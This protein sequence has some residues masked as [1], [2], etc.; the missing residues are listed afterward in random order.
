MPAPAVADEGSGDTST[1]AQP[2]ETTYGVAGS[3]GRFQVFAMV[4]STRGAHQRV[5]LKTDVDEHDPSAE[6]WVSVYPG[7]DWHE[8]ETWEMFGI[9]FDGHPALRHLYLPFEFE[10]HPLR[11]DYPLLAREV[12][13]WPGLV[14]VEPMPGEDGDDEERGRGGGVVTTGTE[15][16]PPNQLPEVHVDPQ[17]LRQLA[18]AQVN[19]ELDTGD[20][21]LNLG[22]QHPATHGTLRLVVRLD[23]ERVIAADPVI[24][25]MHR[26]YEKL[27]EFRTYPQITTLINRID[28]LSSFANE[29]PFIAGAEM[30]MGIEAPPRALYI[31][32]VLTEL[33]R[34]ATFLL[35]LGEMGLQVGAITPAFYGFRDRE[36]VLNLIEGVTGGRFHPNFNR[37]GGLKDDLPWGWVSECRSTMRKV[38]ESCDEFENLVVG[39]PIFEQRTRS[40][41]IIPAELGAAYGVS[42]SNLRAS[43]VDWDLRR[44]GNP[45]LPYD[46]L[47]W[48][49]WTHPDGDS[50][51][52]YWV[53]LQETRESAR[54][55]LQLVEQMPS[56]PI[57]AKVPRIIKVPRARS[58]STPRTRSARWA[59]TSS[60]R[61]RPGRSA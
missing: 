23:G 28:W 18:E 27:T 4:A 22:P 31:R 17:M 37:I 46:E 19:V 45:H 33:S 29:V 25:Y 52:R 58:G 24:G 42:G 57:M 20:M 41:G 1:P 48:K 2:K 26:G 43:G 38:L 7:A 9:A 11:K 59:T 32:T 14:D 3:A 60:R 47:D 36:Y 10:G 21:I 13:P 16:P 56:G 5:V 34:I 40:I 6:S 30:L 49:V 39:N 51:A 44:D 53:R 50:F 8:R 12:K 55:V 61:A 15:L 35:F 54:M